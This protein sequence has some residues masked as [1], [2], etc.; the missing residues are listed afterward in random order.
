MNHSQL[1]QSPMLALLVLRC[2][3]STCSLVVNV[4]FTSFLK[5]WVSSRC[6]TS[7]NSLTPAQWVEP[8]SQILVLKSSSCSLCEFFSW[9]DKILV[10]KVITVLFLA[11]H[12]RNVFH[13]SRK[14]WY[15][16][17]TCSYWHTVSIKSPSP[18][19][20]MTF[21][22]NTWDDQVVPMSIWWHST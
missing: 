20:S 13:H 1:T 7:V 3:T 14:A 22:N 15:R 12:S 17:R 9:C 11:Y 6:S 16:V 10:K 2:P 21:P 5:N 18:E 19:G 4:K 8:A